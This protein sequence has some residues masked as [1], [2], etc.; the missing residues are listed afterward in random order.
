MIHEFEERNA[1]SQSQQ[2][3][4]FWEAIYRKAFPTLLKL[5]CNTDNIPWQKVGIDR[6]IYLPH[7]KKILVDEKKRS[8]VFP[9]I[10]LEYL[11]ND[12]TNAP[13]W[14]KKDLAIDYL[15]Y[16]FIPSK[17]CYLFP[18]HMLRIAWE[19]YGENWQTWGRGNLYDY[20]IVKAL[21]NN[22]CTWSV[23]VPTADLLQA[24]SN[25]SLIQL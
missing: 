14:V 1:W 4:P 5:E 2:D 9:D 15:A 18:W 7:G 13:G 20:H 6:I 16:A 23:A 22:Y 17:Q 24:V 8:Q 11:S 21:N 10:A 25:A 12:S 3:E 19:N